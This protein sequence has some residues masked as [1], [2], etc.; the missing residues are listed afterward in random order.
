[1]KKIFFIF[2]FLSF[3]TENSAKID[4]KK[5]FHYDTWLRTMGEI[6]NIFEVRYYNEIDVDETMSRAIKGFAEQDPHS[7]FLDKK[8]C[9]KLQE[10]MGGEFFGIGVVLPGDTKKDEEF[11]PIIE[12]VPGGPSDK[13]GVRP[14]DKIIQIDNDIVK[15]LDIDEIMSHLK[16]EK[17]TKV[18]LKVMREKNGEPITIEIM[19][20]KIKDETALMYYFPEHK[21]YY[22]LLSIF[23]E[24]SAKNV[25]KILEQAIKDK[26]NGI[27]IDL[28]NNTGG[29]FDSAIDIAS[30]FL[31]KGSDVVSTKDRSG[32]ITGEWKT[33]RSPLKIPP[34]LPIFF[35]VNNYTAS[36]GE[37]LAGTL[38]IHAEKKD[39]GFIFI[40]GNETFGKGS[41]QEVIPVNNDSAIKLTTAL[42]FLPFN[43]SIQGKGVTPDF[44]IEYRTPPTETMRWVTLNY[45]KE[46]GLK[47][48]IKPHDEKENKKEDKK[49]GE[50][51]PWKEKRLEILSNDYFIQNALNLIELFNLGHHAFSSELKSRE[52]ALKFLKGHYYIDTKIKAEEIKL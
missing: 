52:K 12:V 27:I 29:L 41:V 35:I 46:K 21:V 23:S 50:T 13:A 48:H 20:D 30:L 32:K 19:R 28:R 31:P 33:T 5:A 2:L 37:I 44:V 18:T 11:I 22:L 47:G 24:K 43:T 42:Y 34:H 7:S 9:K 3:C 26:S 1:M 25:Q 10:K 39:T 14:G 17:N 38:Q 40:L 51:I 36:A 45:G 16:G 49:E 15:G 8:E 6:I 4:E